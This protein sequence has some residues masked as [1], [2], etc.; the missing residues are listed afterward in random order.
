MLT[1]ETHGA[2]SHN[3]ITQRDIIYGVNPRQ[4]STALFVRD[5]VTMGLNINLLLCKSPRKALK[6]NSSSAGISILHTSFTV[7]CFRLKKGNTKHK[8]NRAPTELNSEFDSC[9]LPCVCQE[10][11]SLYFIIFHSRVPEYPDVCGTYMCGKGYAYLHGTRLCGQSNGAFSWAQ[12]RSNFQRARLRRKGL[13]HVS[14]HHQTFP[15]PTLDR[16]VNS[17]GNIQNKVLNVRMFARG[18]P[19]T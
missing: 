18:A 6:H 16:G 19:R 13:S 14:R 15:N 4:D 11:V 2:W 9:T 1:T 10:E 3:Q 7:V 5:P 8:Q 17:A 12:G